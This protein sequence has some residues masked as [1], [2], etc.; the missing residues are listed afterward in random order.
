[1]FEEVEIP[2]MSLKEQQRDVSKGAVRVGEVRVLEVMLVMEV[3]GVLRN[4]G[5]IV[6]SRGSGFCAAPVCDW[7]AVE[8]WKREGG[9]V[10]A[11]E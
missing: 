1:M 7:K 5:R 2:A 6:K 3:G 8:G 9:G 10:S 11:Y 4:G